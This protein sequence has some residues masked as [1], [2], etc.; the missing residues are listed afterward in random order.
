MVSAPMPEIPYTYS[1]KDS[2]LKYRVN[3]DDNHMDRQWATDK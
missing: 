2:L 3:V 1:K